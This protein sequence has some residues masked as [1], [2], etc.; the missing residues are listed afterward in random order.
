MAR[1]PAG[2]L[3][4]IARKDW[5][6]GNERPFA[7]IG[8]HHMLVCEPA[9]ELLADDVDAAELAH[10]WNAYPILVAAIAR[11]AKASN[12]RHAATAAN[13]VLDQLKKGVA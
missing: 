9:D 5:D 2:T 3:T 8:M 10:R 1:K 4:A 11:I 7:R 12:V 13:E 6:A